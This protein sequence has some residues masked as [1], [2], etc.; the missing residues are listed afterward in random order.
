M[1]PYF[2]SR[3]NVKTVILAALHDI[4]IIFADLTTFRLTNGVVFPT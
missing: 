1:I 4:K 2:L 3:I